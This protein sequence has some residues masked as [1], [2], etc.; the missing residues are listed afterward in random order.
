[1]LSKEERII[2]IIIFVVVRKKDQPWIVQQT[3]RSVKSDGCCTRRDATQGEY[4]RYGMDREERW[5][6]VERGER[7]ERERERKYRVLE[8]GVILHRPNRQ[9]SYTSRPRRDLPIL[10]NWETW[11][12]LILHSTS[13]FYPSHLP[14][15]EIRLPP[16]LGPLSLIPPSPLSLPT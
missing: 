11:S 3:K 7:R 13:S 16:S 14:Q 5:A 1:M 6:P 9:R 15:I 4:R 2:I 10:T 12:P 8:L